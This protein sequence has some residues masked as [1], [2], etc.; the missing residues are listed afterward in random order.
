MDEVVM[1]EK[2]EKGKRI[3][4]TSGRTEFK[5]YESEKSRNLVGLICYENNRRRY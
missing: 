4:Y 3:I 2:L 1:V 5:P